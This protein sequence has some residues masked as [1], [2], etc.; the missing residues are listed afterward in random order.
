MSTE[1]LTFKISLSG[2]FWDKR[3][4][5]SIW[6]DED[7][8]FHSE[9]PDDKLHTFTV[10]HEVLTGEH[11]LQIRLENKTSH[12][13]VID[14]GNIVKD[15]LLNI[16]DIEIND[17]SLGQLKW[18]A[19]F[20]LDTPQMY[21]GEKITQLAHCVNLG[22]NGAYVLKFNSPFYLWLLEKL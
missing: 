13:T 8:V 12:D 7:V 20:V 4:Q 5:F 6:I 19:I 22:W 14:N 10:D 16:E 18:D 11:T 15:M 2:T 9:L 17:I 21:H 3:P 1:S